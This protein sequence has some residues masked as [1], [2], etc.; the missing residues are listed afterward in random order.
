[1]PTRYTLTPKYHRIGICAHVR[2]GL[3]PGLEGRLRL[4]DP[5]LVLLDRPLRLAEYVDEFTPPTVLCDLRQ[6][7]NYDPS[8][9]YTYVADLHEEPFND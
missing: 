6:V 2:E 1:M 4:G 7:Q 9:W 3:P 8:Y 5:S